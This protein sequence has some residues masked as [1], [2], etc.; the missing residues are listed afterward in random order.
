[1]ALGRL[2]VWAL[3]ELLKSQDLNSEFDNLIAA[4]LAVSTQAAQSISPA[5]LTDGANPEVFFGEI[6]FNE[7]VTGTGLNPLSDTGLTIT[8]GQGTAYILQTSTSPTKLVRVSKASST[9]VTVP[10]ST[11]GFIDLGVDGVFDISTNAPGAAVDH[12]RLISFTTD[13][14]TVTV[15]PTDIADRIFLDNVKFPD[16]IN[17]VIIEVS[18][19]TTG[20][21]KA[22][23]SM[24]DSTNVNIITFSADVAFDI[25][26]TGAGGRDQGA[27]AGNTWY[28]L[29]V[30]EDTTGGNAQS[31]LLVA[32]IDFPASVVLPTGYDIFRRV[33]WV[34][35]DAGTNFLQ[36]IG[37]DGWF[38]YDDDQNVLTGGASAAFAAVD[39]SSVVPP[40][41][42]RCQIVDSGPSGDRFTRITGSGAATGNRVFRAGDQMN[43]FLQSVDAAQSYDY[44]T[45]AGSATHDVQG[46][47]DTLE[48][49]N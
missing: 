4:I 7:I 35:N 44:K 39:V 1:M 47:Q 10:A 43:T 3:G 8:V 27:E 15:G 36:G 31:T 30:I 13:G 33:G 25:T 42:R 21:V 12:I 37:V 41:S 5:S 28:A 9:V 49:E 17:N 38:V 24:Y 19:A 22:G 11:I 16:E 18:A 40:T 45:S 34:R 26:V 14:S 29:L 20:T 32:D 23:A 2:K 46:Y 48:R 6:F